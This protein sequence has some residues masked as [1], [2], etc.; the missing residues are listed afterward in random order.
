MD[1]KLKG[2]NA[3]V[4]GGTKGIGRAIVEGLIAEG[5]NVAF[6]ARNAEEI[7]KTEGALAKVGPKVLGTALDVGDAKRLEQWVNDSAKTLQCKCIGHSGK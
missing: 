7:K 1:L 3:I 5:V 4:T 2:L 6:C